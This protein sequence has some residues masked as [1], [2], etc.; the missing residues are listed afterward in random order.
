MKTITISFA[1]AIWFFAL[2]P[3]M[4]QTVGGEL[5]DGLYR[6][7][8]D[9]RFNNPVPITHI[10]SEHDIRLPDYLDKVLSA[11]SVEFYDNRYEERIVAVSSLWGY[12]QAG[13]VYVAHGSEGSFWNPPYFGFYQMVLVGRVCYYTAQEAVYRSLSAPPTMGMYY[14]PMMMQSTTVTDSRPV[15]IVLEWESGRK[16]LVSTGQLSGM[17]PDLVMDLIRSDGGLLEQFNA[18]DGREQKR[19]GMFYIRKF[20]ERNPVVLPE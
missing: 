5:K 19:M 4:A 1:C 20:N 18:L 3:S 8:D 11:D 17:P 7:F 12:C 14:D 6:S 16:R 15:Q 9:L 2:L 10:L 13:R